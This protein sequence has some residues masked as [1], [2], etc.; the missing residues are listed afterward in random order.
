MA[1]QFYFP[2][3]VGVLVVFVELHFAFILSNIGMVI[4]G[5]TACNWCFH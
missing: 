4:V 5:S 1:G 2:L 3:E